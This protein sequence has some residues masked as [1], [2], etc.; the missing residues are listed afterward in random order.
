M[1]ISTRS[2]RPT[3]LRTLCAPTRTIE[4]RATRQRDA[5]R[6]RACTERGP[7]AIGPNMWRALH[8]ATV[9]PPKTLRVSDARAFDRARRDTRRSGVDRS[10][11]GAPARPAGRSIEICPWEHLS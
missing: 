6:S 7:R 9:L 10:S 1:K 5:D 11:R 3:D 2:P 8:D 4:R